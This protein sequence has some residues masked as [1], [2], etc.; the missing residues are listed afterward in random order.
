MSQLVTRNYRGMTFHFRKDGWLNMTKA[1][2]AFGKR[3]DKYWDA[4][5]TPEYLDAMEQTPEF[6]GLPLTEAKRS[7]RYRRKAHLR[8]LQPHS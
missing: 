4:V 3:V 6:R 8:G 2:K 1:A 7:C 5:E